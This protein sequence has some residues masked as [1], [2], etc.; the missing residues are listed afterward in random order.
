[1]AVGNVGFAARLEKETTLNTQLKRFLSRYFY[2]S[3]SLVMSAIVVW[4]FSHTV[5]QNLFHAKPAKPLLLW[6]H[7]AAFSTWMVLFIAQSG[8]IRIRKVSIHRRLGWFGAA[9]AATMVALGLAVAVYLSRWDIVVLHQPDVPQFLSIPFFDMAVFGGCMA[10]AILW[11]KKPDFHRRLVFIATCEL[12]DAGFGRS[13]FWFNHNLFYVGVD[14]LIVAGMV[15][16]QIVDGRVHKVYLYAL[17][18]MIV[19]QTFTVYVWRANPAWWQA[20][21]HAILG[22]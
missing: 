2:F 7:G 21:T 19:G 10:L 22:V 3:M 8:L 5:S 6:I 14:L 13:D 1:M 18:L 16:D 20:T 15:R 4:G 11:R 12:M 17:P 9:L